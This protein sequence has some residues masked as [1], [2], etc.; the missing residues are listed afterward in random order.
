[1]TSENVLRHRRLGD[2]RRRRRAGARLLEHLARRR[3]RERVAPGDDLVERDAERIDVAARIEVGAGGLF[4]RH[5]MRRAE[6][7]LLVRADGVLVLHVAGEAEVGQL[8]AAGRRDHDVAGLHV[9]MEHAEPRGMLEGARDLHDQAARFERRQ[10]AALPKQ[11]AQGAAL[12]VFHHEVVMPVGLGNVDRL[13][14]V[15]MVQPGGGAGFLEESLDEDGVL[16]EPGGEHLDGDDAVHAHLVGAVDMAH[17]AAREFRAQLV[18]GNLNR[19]FSV[20]TGHGFPMPISDC[21]MPNAVTGVLTRAATPRR[22]APSASRGATDRRTGSALP[23]R[24]PPSSRRCGRWS[25]G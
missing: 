7:H 3:R 8:R 12:D 20:G 25:R 13:D 9:E 1:M 10:L 2:A 11:R 19:L 17:A 5:V 6:D 22:G 14:D 24:A 4:G 18:A 15:G 16:G 23:D 21:R